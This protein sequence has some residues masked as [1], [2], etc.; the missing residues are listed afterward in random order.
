MWGASSHTTSDCNVAID[1]RHFWRP[2]HFGNPSLLRLHDALPAASRLQQERRRTRLSPM[3]KARSRIA[4]PRLGCAS[5]HDCAL[6]ACTPRCPHA[7]P[8]PP[9]SCLLSCASLPPT[10][11]AAA[12][13]LC[14][15]TPPWQRL[16]CAPGCCSLVAVYTALLPCGICAVL[17]GL[18]LTDS[19]I[20]DQARVYGGRV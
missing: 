10:V 14:H 4:P 2:P 15:R 8:T 9:A 7:H 18:V 20:P 13:G 16:C 11:V 5:W 3:R 17:C 19:N 1:A 6:L 12:T